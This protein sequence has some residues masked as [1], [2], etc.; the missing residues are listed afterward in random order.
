MAKFKSAFVC[1][2][3]G[4]SSPRWTGRCGDCGA[5]NSLVQESGSHLSPKGG[6][7]TPA[8]MESLALDDKTLPQRKK[9]NIG[10]FDRALGGGI[11]AGSIVLIGGEPGIGKSTLA[12]QAAAALAQSSD[13]VY[14]SGEEAAEQIRLRA[15]RL[16]VGTSALKLIT[17]TNLNRIL[18]LFE[19]QKS[20]A[21]L[22]IDSIQTMWLESVDGSAGTITQ[23]RAATQRLVQFAK[24]TNTAIIL[25]GHVTKDGQIAGPNVI[26]HMVDAVMHFEG[27]SNHQFRILRAVKNRYGAAEEIGVFEMVKSGL[28]PIEN[29]SALFLGEDEETQSGAAVFAGIE[30]TRP[31][32]VEIQALTTPSHFGQARRAAVGCDPSRLSMLLAVME[33]RGGWN[34]STQDVYLNVAGGLRITDPAADLAIAAALISALQNKAWAKKTIFFGEISLSGA[35]R[36]V[37]RQD[38]RLKEA[39][40][41]GFLTAIAPLDN[42][43]TLKYQKKIKSVKDLQLHLNPIT[44]KE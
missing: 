13:A 35:V 15:N 26:A 39:Q 42:T 36:S 5:W 4:V 28:S 11:V 22:I 32:L 40:K 3:C 44:I 6:K 16:G 7:V 9:T 41:L 14:I 24:R 19:T 21:V 34:F 38:V 1:Q 12:L 31:L 33:A 2:S 30:G 25:I 37:A 8:I 18:A 10:E 20:P 29:P 43:K 17:E 23:L 27:S